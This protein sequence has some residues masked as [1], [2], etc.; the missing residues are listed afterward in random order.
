MKISPSLLKTIA[1]SLF[2]GGVITSCS[3]EKAFNT[4]N[5]AFKAE[6]KKQKK[7]HKKLEKLDRKAKR[8]HDNCPN[9][10]MG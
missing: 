7:L 8:Y 4:Q 6:Y 10:G 1:A 5:K 3:S 2:L 9:C